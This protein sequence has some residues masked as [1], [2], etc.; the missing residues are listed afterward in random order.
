MA[1]ILDNPDAA[2]CQA[3]G[4]GKGLFGARRTRW[5]IERI[6]RRR[7]ERAMASSG[8]TD[9]EAMDLPTSW[10]DPGNLLQQGLSQRTQPESRHRATAVAD[11]GRT[12]CA[13]AERSAAQPP[14][15]SQAMNEV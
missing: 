1:G 9:P 6:G 15:D 14:E 11:S 10:R 3:Q 5:R 13:A 12:G 8:G 4:D 7:I 2:Y